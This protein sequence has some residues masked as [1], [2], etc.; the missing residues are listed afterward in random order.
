[1]KV[2][3]IEEH[4]SNYPNPITFEPG[5]TLQLGKQ[6]TEFEGWIRVTTKDGNEGWAPIQYIEF[7][8][9][10]SQGD[11]KCSY[12]ANELNTKLSEPLSV[13]TELNGWYLVSNEQG[14]VGWVP[15]HTVKVA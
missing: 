6:D 15:V 1:M 4:I 3:V 8:A 9:G 12:N 7:E 2:T 11:A 14:E 13:L 5:E 10:A